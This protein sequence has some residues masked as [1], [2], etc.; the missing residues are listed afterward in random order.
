MIEAT[1]RALDA[2]LTRYPKA[3]GE[4]WFKE[5]VIAHMAAEHGL[6]DLAPEHVIC[7]YGGQEGL[8]LVVSCMSSSRPYLQVRKGCR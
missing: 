8:Q 5:A 6:T 1:K 3:G 7:T 2:G 4:P